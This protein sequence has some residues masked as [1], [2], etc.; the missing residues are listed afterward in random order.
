MK[1]TAIFFLICLVCLWGPGPA[2]GQALPDPLPTAPDH[3][4]KGG[5][6][7]RAPVNGTIRLGVDAADAG[8]LDP[9]FA[10][11]IQDRPLADMVFNGLVRYI[12][13][14]AP[15]IEPDLAAGI[16][17]PRLDREGK[18]IWTFRL[19]KGVM[20]QPGPANEAYE[21]TADDVVFSLGKAADPGTSAYAGEYVGLT[22]KKVDDYTVSLILDKPLSPILFL[23]KVANYA[24]GFIV[25]QRAVRDGGLALFQK[26]P[27]GTGTIQVRKLR[28][29]GKNPSK[30][31]S[32]LFPR[33]S[34]PFPAWIFVSCRKGINGN[35]PCWMENWM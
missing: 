19:K 21:L 30:G 9:H 28:S 18:Q 4:D 14:K 24:G 11:G 3:G 13:G 27:V 32:T 12:P 31:P 10:A 15:R 1:K 29:R 2:A 8:T 7:G 23:P 25:S 6:P 34:G 22:V 17:E 20:F 35:R 16:P 33:L 5:P 26:H